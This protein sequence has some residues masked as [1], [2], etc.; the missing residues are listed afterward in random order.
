MKY[1]TEIQ[2]LITSVIVAFII[3]ITLISLIVSI[4]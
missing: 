2:N 1:K 4:L 3:V